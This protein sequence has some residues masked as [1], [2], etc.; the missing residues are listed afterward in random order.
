[1][2]G[3]GQMF[4]KI[5]G[6]TKWPTAAALLLAFGALGAAPPEV[7]FKKHPYL[8]GLGASRVAVR[9]ELD[10]AAPARLEID[11]KVVAKDDAAITFHELAA[12]GLSPSTTYH[13][14]VVA[15]SAEDDVTFTTA[16]A[17]DAASPVSFLVY[18]DN[19]TDDVAHTAV[20]RAM[21]SATGDFLV[22]TGDLVQDGSDAELWQRFFDV[23]GPMLRERCLFTAV[24]NHELLE[25]TATN[26]LQYFGAPPDDAPLAIAADGGAIDGGP[27]AK[28]DASVAANAAPLTG[29]RALFRT[30]RWGQVR[31]F[32]LNG[33]DTF[34]SGE[35]RDWLDK[36]LAR[37]DAEPGVTWRIVVVHHGPW[38]SGP[39]GGNPRI[40]A[41]RL[42]EMWRSH[43]VDL[44]LSGHD[45][46]Y[47]RGAARG[48]KYIVSGGG[49]AP[50]YRIK[51]EDDTASKVESTL[52]YI[53]AKIDKKHFGMVVHR[54]DGSILERCGFDQ[55]AGGSGP[56][57]CGAKDTPSDEKAPAVTSAKPEQ[58]STQNVT[59]PATS[60]CACDAIGRRPSS[61]GALGALFGVLAALFVRARTKRQSADCAVR[62]S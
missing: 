7:H 20:V 15:G 44:V 4:S 25:E 13:G 51:A 24:G 45:H 56:W 49:G 28:L 59:P 18:G 16:P 2:N 36:A 26:F 1:M 46:I 50:L 35:E 29:T 21:R 32:F 6:T 39:H 47:E 40:L 42:P 55:E 48:L 57:T 62:S 53:E 14:H 5:R 61:P 10:G 37:A 8:Q 11:K 27:R 60:R 52:H 34:V 19:R 31:F 33:M 43:H 41:A 23:E 17:D 58:G 38:S 12:T 30:A 54:A 3:A 22:N 9:F